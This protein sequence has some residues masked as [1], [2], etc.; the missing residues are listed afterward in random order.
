MDG[1]LKRLQG[2]LD[3]LCSQEKGAKENT[4]TTQ[5]PVRSVFAITE[6]IC[7]VPVKIKSNMK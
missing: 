2:A 4:I 6:S 1:S 5:N 3:T 7:D